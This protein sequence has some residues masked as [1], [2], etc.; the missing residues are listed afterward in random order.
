[1][2][3]DVLRS[4]ETESVQR[5][6]L[7]QAIDEIGGLD[8]PAGRDIGFADL[9]LT[10]QDVLSDLAP[11]ATGVRSAA[12]HALETNDAHGEV[13][14]SHSVRLT[15][16]NLR[17]HVA[18]RTGRVLLVFRVPNTSDAQVCNLEVAIR[19]EQN[20]SIDAE[21]RRHRFAEAEA[22][23]WSRVAQLLAE[24]DEPRLASVALDLRGQPRML[25]AIAIRHSK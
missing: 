5:L 1:M 23:T 22:L 7:D 10:G 2:V 18:W 9:N 21:S 6:A 16:H 8:R 4:I 14:N 3:F 25:A 24:G 20:D 19:I 12:K 11:V 15:A 13:V 17:R